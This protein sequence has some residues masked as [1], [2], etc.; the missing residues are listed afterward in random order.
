MMVKLRA[1][2]LRAAIAQSTR[3]MIKKIVILLLSFFLF[4]ACAPKNT[5]KVD[6]Q[7]PSIAPDLLK[8]APTYGPNEPEPQL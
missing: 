3:L 2:L 6:F 5:P 7:G 8:I 4:A 1:R